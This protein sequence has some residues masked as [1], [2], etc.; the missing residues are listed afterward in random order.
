MFFPYLCLDHNTSLECRWCC[1]AACSTLSLEKVAYFVSLC[2]I[3]DRKLVCS[4]AGESSQLLGNVLW[5]DS[6]SGPPW[7]SVLESTVCV[8]GVSETAGV[9]CLILQRK[10]YQTKSRKL[11]WINL[12]TDLALS[13]N[14][15]RWPPTITITTFFV[16]VEVVIPAQFRFLRKTNMQKC[17]QIKDILIFDFLF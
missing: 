10:K 8:G 1:G 9:S 13:Q 5:F 3:T 12:L 11:F 14:S 17:K 4:A 7:A 15:L 16:S 2:F 6:C